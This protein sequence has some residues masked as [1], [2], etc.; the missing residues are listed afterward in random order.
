MTAMTSTPSI[1]L[2]E[3]LPAEVLRRVSGGLAS[4]RNYPVFSWPWLRRRSLLFVLFVG[5]FGVLS[6]LGTYATQRD[7]RGAISVFVSFTVGFLLISTL[8][9]L[10]ATAV[11]HARLGLRKERML[12]VAA[13]LVGLGTSYLADEWA[14]GGIEETWRGRFRR[15]AG[16]PETE[17]RA[18]NASA[19]WRSTWRCWS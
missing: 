19:R 18:A 13:L 4:Y 3:P 10:L 15:P 9:P 1:R 16:R 17:E 12:V 7:L 5:S 6:G 14:S 11:R 2:D 8:G